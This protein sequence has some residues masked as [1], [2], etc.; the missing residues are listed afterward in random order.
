MG[1]AMQNKR[2]GKFAILGG[3]VLAAFAWYQIYC[4][5]V[6]GQMFGRGAR[7]FTY[8]EEPGW[9]VFGLVGYVLAALLFSTAIAVNLV[10][11]RRA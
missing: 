4:V 5:I 7:W 9:F 8:A 2:A 1:E 3:G 6:Y 11:D 10:G